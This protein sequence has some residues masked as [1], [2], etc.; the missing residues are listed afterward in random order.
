MRGHL[1]VRRYARALFEASRDASLL[2]ALE[3]DI[4]VLK[5]LMEETP[6][7]RDFCLSPAQ[8]LSKNRSF[9]EIAF[10]PY[11]SEL[12]GRTVEI[13]C[14]NSRLEAIP[15]LT[16]ALEDQLDMSRGITK[17]QVESASELDDSEKKNILLKL[18]KRIGGQIRVDWLTR[19]NLQG[20]MTFQWNNRF[21]DLS[22]KSRLNGLKSVLKRKTI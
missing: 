14:Q 15:Y 21:L 11:L 4:A 7:I 6:E 17:F 22:L 12:T 13:I 16:E 2:K 18:E 3:E 1:V 10:L 20:G 8:S 19:K 9:I 5:R